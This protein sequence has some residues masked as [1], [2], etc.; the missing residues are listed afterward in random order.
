MFVALFAA[1]ALNVVTVNFSIYD[2]QGFVSVGFGTMALP[3]NYVFGSA[4]IRCFHSAFKS[5]TI[6][7]IYDT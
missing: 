3:F 5:S 1:L 7:Y 2:I 4:S 6:V